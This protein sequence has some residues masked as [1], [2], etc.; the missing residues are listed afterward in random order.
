LKRG[1]KKVMGFYYLVMGFE[2]Y[3]AQLLKRKKKVNIS[4]K[5]NLHITF[6]QIT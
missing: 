4:A 2:L 1:S 6:F 3:G 5:N